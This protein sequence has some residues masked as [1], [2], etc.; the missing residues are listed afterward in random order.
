MADNFE[1]LSDDAPES[2]QVDQTS[3]RRTLK[4]RMEKVPKHLKQG[5]NEK[6]MDGSHDTLGQA[7]RGGLLYPRVE[8]VLQGNQGY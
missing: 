8:D 4:K 3:E 7:I 6:E 5:V 2:M 1:Q